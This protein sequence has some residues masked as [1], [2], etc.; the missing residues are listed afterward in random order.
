MKTSRGYA[1]LA[2]A[3]VTSFGVT[4]ARASV[5]NDQC[6]MATIV[7]SLPYDSGPNSVVGA[8]TDPGDP[9]QTC[10]DGSQGASSVWF[11][12]TAPADVTLLAATYN[13]YDTVLS[14][15]QGSCG[16]LTELAC[17]HKAFGTENFSLLLVDVSAGQ[18]VYFEVTRYGAG[19]D[20][21]VGLALESLNNSGAVADPPHDVGGPG[22][23]LSGVSVCRKADEIVVRMDLYQDPGRW[24]AYVDID[25]DQNRQT[26]TASIIDQETP[27]ISGLGVEYRIAY[28]SADPSG[29]AD[30]VNTSTSTPSGVAQ[31]FSSPT[32][33]AFAIPLSALG[34]DDGNVNIAVT[35]GQL[36]F[37]TFGGYYFEARDAAPND[38]NVASVACPVPTCGAAPVAPCRAPLAPGK[39]GLQIKDSA[40]DKADQ[41]KWSWGDGTATSLAE[42]GLPG[43]AT[44]YGVCIYDETANTPTLVWSA[45]LP[46]GG[47]CGSKPC[48]KSSSKGFSY[49]DKL[50]AHG[51][52]TALKLT[53]GADGKVKISLAGK[54]L[55]LSPPAIPLSQDSTV[56]VQVL[57]NDGCWGAAFTTPAKK[58]AD[59]KFQD[60]SD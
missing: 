49:G 21:S 7:P 53:A 50:G 39:S 47:T 30:V 32:V 4:S 28:D 37:H 19:P 8:T 23:D 12:Y 15:H 31:V 36:V 24:L 18:T 26:G 58:N 34:N 1:V 57:G 35:V 16:A 45:S 59:G 29:S 13:D 42:F 2:M 17:N 27:Y 40:S 52:V 46:A 55:N 5:P 20:G 44:D 43:L 9:V 25:A 11:A 10:G 54:G 48:W 22:P 56:T 38:G 3:L 60:K 6:A 41:L 14:V 51:G 33:A